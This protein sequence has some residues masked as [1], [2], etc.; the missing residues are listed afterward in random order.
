MFRFYSIELSNA[1]YKYKS[2]NFWMT[3]E[4]NSSKNIK[5]GPDTKKSV[6][7]FIWMYSWLF[8]TFLQSMN[9][10]SV[11]SNGFE[12]LKEEGSSTIY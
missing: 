12:F 4:N 6:F 7:N 8:S 1:S 10:A 11:V 2:V 9:V 5:E 3:E